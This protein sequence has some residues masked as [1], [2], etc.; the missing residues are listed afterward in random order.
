MEKVGDCQFNEE[1]LQ[2]IIKE[3]SMKYNGE[4]K[5]FLTGFEAGTHVLWAIVLNHPEWLK[6]AASV[7]GNFK[8][9]CAEP[10]KISTDIS[11]KNLPIKSFVGDKDEYFSPSGKLYNQ[12]TEVKSL[13]ASHGFENISETV[14]SNK[15]HAPMPGEVMNYFNSLLK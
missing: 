12:W 6:A 14:L 1:G 11:R 15:D 4:Q 7:A 9:R 8:N 5:V 13:A 10:S 3:V 2:N